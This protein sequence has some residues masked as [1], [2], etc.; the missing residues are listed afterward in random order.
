MSNLQLLY[1]TATWCQPCKIFGPIM[2][3]ISKEFLVRKF[4]IEDVSEMVDNLNILSVPTV[5]LLD[6]TGQEKSRIVGART[7]D[8]VLEWLKENK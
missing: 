4:D 8:M 5:V 2:D 3:E 7:K 1:F 6:K